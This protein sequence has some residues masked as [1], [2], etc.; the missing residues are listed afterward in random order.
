MKIC[1]P[2]RKNDGKEYTDL[3]EIMDR[4]GREPHGSWLAGTNCL[5]HGGIHISD[6]SAPGSILKEDNADAAI[7]LQ[8]MADGE[9]VA[10]RINKDYLTNIYNKQTLQYSST[11]VLIKSICK[12]DPQQESTW[13]VFYSL[14]MGLAPLSAY[15]KSRTIKALKTV[16]RHPAGSHDASISADGVADISPGQGY[17]NAGSRAIIL[18]QAQFRNHG[19]IQPFG[20]VKSLNDKGVATG[21]AFWVTLLPE[22]M[23]QAGEHYAALPAWQQ[24]AVAQGEFNS[25]VKPPTSVSIR[26]GDAVGF[27]AKDID[28]VGMGKAVTS[29]FAHIEV[30]STDSH[31]PDFL[32]NPGKVTTGKKYIRLGLHKPLYIKTGEMFEKISA[33]TERDGGKVLERDKCNPQTSNGKTWYQIR[34]HTWMSQ[35][36][37]DELNQYDLT[38]REFCALVEESDCDMKKSLR[39][40]WMRDA[41]SWLAERI[42]PDKG[43]LQAAVSRFYKAM[44]DRLDTDQDGMMSDR[45]IFN[46]IHHPEMGVRR[47]VSRLVVKHDSEWFGGSSHHKWATYFQNFDMLRI[48]HAKIWLDECEWMSQ[49][50]PFD[51]GDAVW[52]MHPIVF[53]DALK[54]SVL[55]LGEARVRAVMRMLRVGEGTVG[56]AG[57]ETLF[58]GQSFIKSYHKDFSDHPQVS[59]TRGNLTSSA[60]GAYQVMGYTWNDPK[61]VSLRADAGIVDFTPKSQDEFC[62]LIFKYKRKHS[63]DK[64]MSG[65]I[66]GALDI[67]SYEW[68]SL[69][70]GRYGQPAKSKPEA[71][72]LYNY[73]LDEELSGRTDLHLDIGYITTVMES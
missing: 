47:I 65:D 42:N 64:I 5:W 16:L 22:Y 56:E 2:A 45:E 34:P 46:A 36:D 20:L 8:C 18:K 4:I 33:I 73:Y 24:H 62:V 3:K 69:P 10:W 9:V 59:I 57:Y 11:F 32:S 26:A 12:P 63:L 29:Y 7:P 66:D 31:M 41:Y 53:L 52:H 40:G 58:G 28:P 25:V 70:P 37:V 54:F 39:E 43:M 51:K 14:Y 61:M 72:S 49:V 71:L 1:F 35:D 27:L 60:A 23:T 50:P 67:L 21:E 68:A 38:E 44:L 30:L 6:V 15:P 13:L 17:F 48:N 55:S 19:Q